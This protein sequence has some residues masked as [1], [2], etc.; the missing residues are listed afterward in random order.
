MSVTSVLIAV[1]DPGIR[2]LA[3]EILAGAGVSC[4]IG[5]K[6]GEAAPLFRTYRPDGVLLAIGPSREGAAAARPIKAEWPETIVVLLTP[7]DEHALGTT[8]KT[9]VDALL[10]KRLLRQ[11]LLAMLPRLGSARG[12]LWDGMERRHGLQGT[13]PRDVTERRRARSLPVRRAA[14]GRL[15]SRNGMP[16]GHSSHVRP[17][18]SGLYRIPFV[19]PCDIAGRR[20]ANICDLSAGGVYIALK[21]VPDVGEGFAISFALPGREN[22]LTVHSVVTWRNALWDRRALDLPPGCGLRFLGLQP[23]DL[24]LIHALVSSRVTS[25]KLPW[26]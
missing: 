19:R 9:G 4:V 2:P 16:A 18:S 7:R 21:P 10:P 22:P 6:P 13:R 3:V 24:Q 1:A 11:A 25:P 5:D 17:R 14:M 8:G 23:Q 12:E 26:A 20:G 15:E